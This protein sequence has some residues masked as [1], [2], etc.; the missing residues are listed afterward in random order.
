MDKA[1]EKAEIRRNIWTLGTNIHEL[2]CNSPEQN[3]KA[4]IKLLNLKDGVI[5]TNNTLI[6]FTADL[7][8]EHEALMKKFEEV[9]KIKIDKNEHGMPQNAWYVVSEILFDFLQWRSEEDNKMR[10]NSYDSKEY[11]YQGNLAEAMKKWGFQDPELCY[12]IYE[13][14]H[15]VGMQRMWKKA[16]ETESI[17]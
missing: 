7:R 16:H 6:K 2:D 15:W 12:Y 4:L 5:Y 13:L 14:T 10:F 11:I 8:M 3:S 1:I 9:T 17:K